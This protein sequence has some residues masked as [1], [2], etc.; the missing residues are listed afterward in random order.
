MISDLGKREAFFYEQL[1]GHEH[2]IRT[3]GSIDNLDNRIIH[4][5]EYAAHHDL[6]SLF[7]GTVFK[8]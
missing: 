5:Q 8:H 4:V 1:N 2:F 7:L 3:F 6:Y